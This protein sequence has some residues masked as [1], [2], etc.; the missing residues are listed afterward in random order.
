MYEETKTLLGKVGLDDFSVESVAT[1]L[2]ETSLRGVDSHGIRLL[3]HYVRSAESGRKNKAPNYKIENKFP[4]IAHIDADNAFGHAVGMKAID[5]G[6]EL[7]DKHGVG[8]I[9]VSNSS[10]PGAMG[11]F[12]LRAA[13]KGY[14]AF[15]FTHADSLQLSYGGKRPYLGTNPV[16]FAAPRKEQ[17]PFCLDM[18]TS[19]IPWNRVMLSRVTGEPLPAGTAA[20]ERGE[21][22]TDP[23]AA[24]SLISI[25]G[26]KGF[27]LA[28]MVEILCSVFTG[29]AFGHAIPAMFTTPIELQRKLGQFY[30]IIRADGCVDLDA[31]EESLSRMSNE[32]K[33]EPS[34][35]GEEV[36]LAG[37]KEIRIAKLR[38]EKGIPLDDTTF[39]EIAN[40]FKS[41][42]MEFRAN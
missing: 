30:M 27:G 35:E 41:Y 14:L 18:A 11:S 24:H 37:D 42:G 32:V 9:G 17:E 21:V 10:H 19:I 28:S 33:S 5:I 23:F 7:A 13:R 26:Y 12:A 29:M 25:G 8:V 16:C 2:C 4:A 38:L 39:E 20:D 36:M 1:G 31:F 6:M 15:A 3:P 34:V 40:T 22:T